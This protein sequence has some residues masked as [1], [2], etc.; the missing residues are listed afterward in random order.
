MPDD[1][2]RRAAQLDFMGAESIQAFYRQIET[3]G[4]ILGIEESLTEQT[5]YDL[6]PE[7]DQPEIEREMGIEPEP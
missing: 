7:I 5:V 6:Y 1:D 3:E 4:I 2:D